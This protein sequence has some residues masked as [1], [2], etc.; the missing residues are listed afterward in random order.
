MIIKKTII[1]DLQSNVVSKDNKKN[2]Y[3]SYR[4]FKNKYTISCFHYNF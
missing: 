4:A 2:N 1:I 3:N